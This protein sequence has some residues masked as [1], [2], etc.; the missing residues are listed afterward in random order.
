[1]TT[2]PSCGAVLVDAALFCEECGAR[3]SSEAPPHPLDVP[4]GASDDDSPI[5]RPTG[6]RRP[7]SADPA[8]VPVECAACGGRIAEDG[9]CERCGSKAPS[10]RDH[11]RE[12]PAPWV[13][14]VCDRGIV[15]SR[16]EDAMALWAEG[17]R[18][19][20]VVCDGVSSSLDSDV[21][22]LA[23]ARAARDVLKAPM[24]R[25][26]G[27]PEAADA[28]AGRVF[29]A[30]AAAANAAVVATTSPDSPS[31]AACTFVAAVLSGSMLRYAVIG[32]SRAYWIP[33]S[34][35]A[36]QLTT[37][38]SMAQMLMAAGMPRARAEAAPQAHAITKWLGKDSPDIVPVAGAL[39]LDGPGWVLVCSDGLWNYASEPAAIAAQVAAAGTEEP[40][41]LAVA[42]VGFANRAGGQDNIT[43][44]LARVLA[45]A[46]EPAAGA[47]L[48][49]DGR[50]SRV[51]EGSARG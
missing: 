46:G 34:G 10:P 32:D 37:D 40:L 24:P 45:P 6:I 19:A 31:P 49:A 30:A 43:V 35:G 22:A 18:A 7:P 33:D 36:L 8:A 12:Q 3:V 9:Y 50:K 16:N 14:G 39:E 5:S 28:A 1:M 41:A 26:A 27:T 25:A 4:V 29:A 48:A 21:A 11:F 44:A 15:H 2:C 20:L 38:D 23:A 47:E 51:E 17:S 13:A 42:L